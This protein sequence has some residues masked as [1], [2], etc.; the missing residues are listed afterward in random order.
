MLAHYK[1]L[2]E[3]NTSQLQSITNAIIENSNSIKEQL[4][5]TI[6]IEASKEDEIAALKEHI[7][8]LEHQ[9]ETLSSA[10]EQLQKEVI[11]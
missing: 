6:P 11:S 8:A 4:Q 5:H 2:H 7:G 10:H 9:L 3:D 1:Q